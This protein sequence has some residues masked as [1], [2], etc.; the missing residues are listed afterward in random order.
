MTTAS[1][2]PG[3]PGALARLDHELRTPLAAIMGYADALRAQA[4]G[5]LS[6]TYI[7]AADSIHAAAGHMLALVERLTSEIEGGRQALSIKRCDVRQVA[8]EAMR[9]VEPGAAEVRLDAPAV[10]PVD[11]DALALR[12]VV[13]NLIA[14]AVAAG[15]GR[16][17]LTLK[18][19][20]GDLVLTVD[21]D[22]PGVAAIAEGTGLVLVRTLVAAHGGVFSLASRPEGGARAQARLPVLAS[23]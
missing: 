8:A 22:G 6:K 4:F 10:L 19:S 23:G 9:L 7:E 14:N 1:D 15:A 11:A 21:D 18:P 5:P 2:P 16:I 13:V 3:E 20:S 12:Q 17:V